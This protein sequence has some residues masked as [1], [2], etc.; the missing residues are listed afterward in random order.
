MIILSCKDLSCQ[1]IINYSRIIKKERVERGGGEH[2]ERAAGLTD[3]PFDFLLISPAAAVEQAEVF[4]SPEQELK[5]QL[6]EG[7]YFL[8]LQKFP[9]QYLHPGYGFVQLRGFQIHC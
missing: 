3:C 5:H 6:A 1:G 7:Y 4:D 9:A 2:T 8:S